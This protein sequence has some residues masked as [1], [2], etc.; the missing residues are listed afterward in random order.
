MKKLLTFLFIV[1]SYVQYTYC[2]SLHI[3]STRF[4]TGNKPGTSI[5]YAIPTADK[6]ILFAGG[7]HGNPGGIIPYFPLDTGVNGN[8]FIGKIDSNRQISWLKI[9]GGTAEDYSQSACQTPD[10]GYAVLAE[11]FSNN[12]N[13]S[14]NHGGNDLWLLKLD[15]AGNLQWQKT[16]GSS[17]SDLAI[18]AANT[19]DNGFILLGAT[20][21]S[22]GDVPFHYGSIWRTDWLVIK[23]DSMGNIQWSKV[24]GGTETEGL[25]SILAIDSSY[26]IVCNSNST[27][28]D[29]TDTAWHAGAS[30]STDYHVVKLDQA[31]NVLWDRSYGGSGS[32]GVSQAIFDIRD[33]SIV[34]AGKTNSTDY[35]VT[36]YHGCDDG[37]MWVVKVK[38]DGTLVWQ[39]TLGSEQRERGN[40]I[41]IETGGGYVVYGSSLKYFCED[42]TIGNI[43]YYDGWI[44]LLDSS[45]NVVTNKV[46]GGIQGET[47]ASVISYQNSY[48]VT[49]FSASFVFTEGTTYGNFD[50]VGGA[51]VTYLGYWPAGII[52]EYGTKE[53]VLTIYPNPA[54]DAVK[55]MLQMDEDGI[56]SI[57][58]TMG[59]VLYTENVTGQ[60]KLVE[61]NTSDWASGMYLVRWSSA[62]VQTI[63]AK[64]IKN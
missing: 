21:G 63:S 3:D 50:S 8:A 6:G 25:G 40:S 36:G 17:A 42:T 57:Y 51:F 58:N 64:L 5:N 19:P 22:D 49:G 16:Y 37:D 62:A 33:S 9:Y 53:P 61:V 28:Q 48:T 23:T 55:I 43:G 54:A 60:N 46:F 13:V 4:I 1:F 20:Y 30:T 38:K 59:Q 32:E 14:G 2:Q 15:A 11:T 44:F 34:I 10:G 56:L 52:N 26:Y 29:C 41:C 24:I 47:P 27:D 7:V 18:S 35:M 45:G 12:G 39:K 31:G